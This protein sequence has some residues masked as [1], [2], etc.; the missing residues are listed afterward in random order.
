M[1]YLSLG[2]DEYYMVATGNSLALN[3]DIQEEQIVPARNRQEFLTIAWEQRIRRYFFVLLVLTFAL[4]SSHLSICF[5]LQ[6][7]GAALLVKKRL[8]FEDMIQTH[9]TSQGPKKVTYEIPHLEAHL[10]RNVDKNGIVMLGSWVE[11]GD[12]LV[13]IKVA[14]FE[15]LSTT[16]K[17]EPD[18]GNAM[19]KSIVTLSN[20]RFAS[21]V[22]FQRLMRDNSSIHHHKRG[23]KIPDWVLGL[24][25]L[26]AYFVSIISIIVRISSFTIRKMDRYERRGN[27]GQTYSKV[28][29]Q[30]SLAAQ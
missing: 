27:R 13:G 6:K 5:G 20:G 16:T 12:I 11:T 26:A 17:M 1:L 30:L 22:C 10:L 15:N 3:Q 28:P 19:M 25:G 24:G 2:R 18:N 9:V 8:S 4:T 14:Y 29:K 23:M 7:L 21:V